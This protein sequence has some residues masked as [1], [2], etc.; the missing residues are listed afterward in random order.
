MRKLFVVSLLVVFVLLS[1][2]IFMLCRV[3][4]GYLFPVLEGGNLIMLA[5]SL[6]AWFLVEAQTGKGKTP[7][8]FIRGVSGASF[9]KLMVCMVAIL[10]YVAL[11][12]DTIHKP[13]I[14]VLMGIYAVYTTV[15]TIMLS[16]L[17][18]IAK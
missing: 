16:K 8:A 7:S 6:A 13:S 3:A 14:F 12:R 5:L 4:P 17:A 11:N 10:I 9:L 2:V 1:I 15:E 18:R